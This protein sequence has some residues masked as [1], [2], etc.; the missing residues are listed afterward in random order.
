MLKTFIDIPSRFVS[1]VICCCCMFDMA[2]ISTPTYPFSLWCRLILKLDGNISELIILRFSHVSL[3]RMIVGSEVLMRFSICGILFLALWKLM[4][5]QRTSLLLMFGVAIE[6]F[7]DEDAT[8]GPGLMLW[9]YASSCE[10]E[11]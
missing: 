3:P 10:Y 4:T 8:G 9:V 5:R 2:A 1:H 6:R 11:L 7:E